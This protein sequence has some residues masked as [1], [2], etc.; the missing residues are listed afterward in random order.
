MYRRMNLNEIKLEYE[1]INQIKRAI[2]DLKIDD[3][4]INNDG[5][6]ND[7]IIINQDRIFR[8]PK[9]DWIL[10]QMDQEK[11]CLSL[12]EDIS[13]MSVPRW[14]SYGNFVGY[15][16]IP[17]EPLS[18]SIILSQP[19]NIQKKW[20]KQ[21]ALF[22]KQ[23]HSIPKEH[24]QQKGIERSLT[25][26]T[27]ND[28]LI[29][30]DEVQQELYPYLNNFTQQRIEELFHHIIG[31]NTFM[32]AEEVLVHGDLQAYHILYSPS[33]KDIT[34]II[35]FG[36]AGLG[37]PAN[38]IATIMN[39]YGESFTALMSDYY[40]EI[41]AMADRARFWAMTFDLQWALG[42]LRTQNPS[43]HFAH[44]GN[45]LDISPIGSKLSITGSGVRQ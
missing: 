30:F 38:D 40:P 21:L 23:M 3:F 42:G 27:Y 1:H 45:A 6:F 13:E 29:L 26:H 33:E 36:T 12:L 20:A 7:I 11:K 9:F 19:K 15:E 4:D 28:W 2:P 14:T 31:D 39:Q 34:G 32:D 41:H 44:F 25:Y 16:R 24:I 5:M 10:E 17:G 22:L 35:D 8:F 43:W 18:R 37:D